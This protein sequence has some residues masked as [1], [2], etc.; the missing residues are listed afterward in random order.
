VNKASRA[1]VAMRTT[2]SVCLAG[3]GM[4]LLTQAALAFDTTK[5]GQGGSLGLDEM[6]PLIEK[7]SALKREVT[8][9]VGRSGQKLDD[10]R[11]DGQRFPGQW[12]NLGGERVSPYVC[13][14]ADKW[15]EVRATVRISGRGKAFEA[16]TPEAMRNATTVTETNPTWKWLDH[17]PN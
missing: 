17:E 10:I 6:M 12:R 3:A 5:L 15:L 7:S 8:A 16:I 13:K 2:A 4:V 14:I 9:A 11:C 1:R